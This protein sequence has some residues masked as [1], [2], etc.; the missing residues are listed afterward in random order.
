M[1]VRVD[2][3][4]HPCVMKKFSLA[5]IFA[6]ALVP[7]L[8]AEDKKLEG[9]AVCAKCQLKTAD[10]CRAAIQVTGADGKKEVYLTEA[11]DQSKDLHSEICKGGKPA[12]VEGTVTEKDGQKLIKITKYEVK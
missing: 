6:L 12:T 9:E 4:P 1:L 3:A 11:N 7:A 10:K 5:A 2:P 8:M